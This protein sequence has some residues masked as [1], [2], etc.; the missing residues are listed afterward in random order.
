[1][2]LLRLAVIG[3]DDNGTALIAT[4]RGEVHA[5]SIVAVDGGIFG[6]LRP[7]PISFTDKQMDLLFELA[8]PLP[9][10]ARD[11]FLRTVARVLSHSG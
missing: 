10:G 8:A 11:G 2:S 4:S 6:Y 3:D 5:A 1:V 7:M 9:V